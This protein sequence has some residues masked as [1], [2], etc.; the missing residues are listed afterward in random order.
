M[1]IKEFW[2]GRYSV[3]EYAYGVD[4]NEYFKEQLDKLSPGKI[5]LPAEGE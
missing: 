3:P 2:D 4:P 1:V 5:L